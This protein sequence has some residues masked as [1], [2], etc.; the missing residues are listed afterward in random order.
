MTPDPV[1]PISKR[2][3]TLLNIAISVIA[4]SGVIALQLYGHSQDSLLEKQLVTSETYQKAVEAEQLRLQILKKLPTFGFNNLMANWVFIQFL[5]YFGDEPAREVTGYHLNHEYFDLI[6]QRDPRWIDI[7]PFLSTAVSFYEAKP[8]L[9]IQYINRGIQALNPEIHPRGWVL[10]RYKA[11]D[12]LLLLGDVPGAIR[13]LSKTAEWVESQDPGLAEV[14]RNTARF[15]QENPDS[16]AP[17]FWAWT[18]VYYQSTDKFVRQRA[19][20]EII[21]MGGKVEETQT[22]EVQFIAPTR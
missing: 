5:L 19:K 4:L 9:T 7:Y 15:L 10:W 2:F 8:E 12:Q 6:I 17:R 1:Q 22:G 13:S 20:E 16:T 21:K 18:T 14:F 11:L 3:G